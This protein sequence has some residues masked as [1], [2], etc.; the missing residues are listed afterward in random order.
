MAERS[1]GLSPTVQI[2]AKS[3]TRPTKNRY[4]SNTDCS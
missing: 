3:S 1:S 2:P 4:Y